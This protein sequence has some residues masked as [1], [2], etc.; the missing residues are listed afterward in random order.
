MKPVKNLVFAL[1]LVFALSATTLAGEVPIPP[2]PPTTPRATTS[3]TDDSTTPLSDPNAVRTGETVET[4]D[5]LMFEAL[6]ALI[7]LY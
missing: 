3:E 2:E 7:Y 1:L 4:S 5:Y 6:I